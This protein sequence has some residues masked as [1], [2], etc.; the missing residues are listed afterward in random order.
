MDSC[1]QV[2]GAPGGIRTHDLKSGSF[3]ELVRLTVAWM[4]C[5]SGGGWW[6]T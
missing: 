6:I 1:K 2:D 4:D 5:V 3:Q